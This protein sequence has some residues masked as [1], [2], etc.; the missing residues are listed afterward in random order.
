M[1]HSATRKRRLINALL[2]LLSCL[3][4]IFSIRVAEVSLANPNELSGW[5][6]FTAVTVLLFYAARKR[7][8]TL[9]LGRVAHWLQ[10]H[11]YTGLFCLFVFF[12]HTG[13][14][15]PNGWF[16]IGL[17]VSLIGTIITGV[18]GLYWSRTLPT[19][20]T[21]LGDEVLYERISGFCAGLRN[22]AEE[23][24]L[25]A[26][27]KTGSHALSDF[28]TR[29]AHGA[30]SR[31]NFH[32]RRLYSNYSPLHRHE[33][34]LMAAKRLMS[35]NEATA[36]ERLQELLQQKDLLDAHFTLQGALKHWLFVHL[37]FSL[38]L[39]PL[40]LLHIILVYSFGLA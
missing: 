32:W 2:L 9:P 26:V 25:A 15:W 17:T 20:L 37:A 27:E 6:L 1:L 29:F 11:I 19:A 22:E 34:K 7:L 14:Q 24:V 30:L 31:P 5:I 33:R 35:S 4:A 13:W 16:E 36:A 12:I 18:V 3:L 23:I 28:Y 38:P 21:R 40:V 39:I 10:V 8:S